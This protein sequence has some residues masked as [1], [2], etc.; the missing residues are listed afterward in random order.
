MDYSD[1]KTWS[2]GKPCNRCQRA[3]TGAKTGEKVPG[4]CTPEECPT[5]VEWF[6]AMPNPAPGRMKYKVPGTA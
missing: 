6:N 2:D 1:R 5:Y 3:D 4:N